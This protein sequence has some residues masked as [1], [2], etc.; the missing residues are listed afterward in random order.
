MLKPRRPLPDSPD[1]VY[2]PVCLLSFSHS[3]GQIQLIRSKLF[4]FI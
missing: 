2:H 3:E 1:L 4:I